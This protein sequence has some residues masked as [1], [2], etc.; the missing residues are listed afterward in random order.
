MKISGLQK[1]SLVDYNEHICAT[2]FTSGC[3]FACPFCHNSGLVKG[4]EP[5]I[6][7]SEIFEYLEKRKNILDSVCISGG[8]PTLHPDL[9]LF[10]SKI[11]QMGYLVKLDTNGTNLEMLKYL[12]E[13]HLIDYI[14][15]DIKN[16]FAKYNLTIDKDLTLTL[17]ETIEYIM[18]CGIDYEFRTTLVDEF[19]NEKDMLEIGKIITGAKR[20]YLQKFVD[21][22]N[23]LKSGLHAVNKETAEHFVQIISKYVTNTFL[24]GY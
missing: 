2:I 14:A 17:K 8:E 18:N 10:I 11:K 21:S 22:G 19:H 23:C 1:V 5:D 7:S 15:M 4:I 13:N 3:N 24:R 12:V 16:S 20:Y 6:P 9:P